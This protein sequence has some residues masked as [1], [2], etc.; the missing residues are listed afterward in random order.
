MNTE[1]LFK[2]LAER[3]LTIPA[4]AEKLGLSASY[5]RLIFRGLKPAKHTARLIA[6]VLGCE[7]F[8]LGW[9]DEPRRAA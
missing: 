7:I 8:D 3:G 4:L 1:L 2:K 6:L 9:K 5:T